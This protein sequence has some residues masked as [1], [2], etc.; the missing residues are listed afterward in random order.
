[1]WIV[2]L[3]LR[4]TYT[5]VVAA[6]LIAVLGAV[7][8]YR[9]ST[10]MFPNIDVPIVSVV[11]QFTGM[12]A[13]EIETRIIFINERVLTASVNNIEH[14]ESQSLDGVGVIR[15]Y[16]HP[17][18]NV[19][20]AETQVTATCQ[21]LLK[22]M[23]PGITP[24]YIVRY[25][26]TSVP[27]V[28]IAVSSDTLTEQQIF[29][30]CQNF[31]IQQLGIVQG[32]RVP[33]PWGGKQRQIMVDLD[34]DR[35]YA[36]GLSPND[37]S[38]AI[39][40]QN[41]IIPAGTAKMGATEYNVKLNS[42]PD[43]IAAFNDVPIKTVNGVPIYVKNVAHVRDG[44]AV[45]TN[46]VRRDGR[47]AVLMTVL[48][49]EGASTLDVVQRVRAALPGIQA[50]LPPE[51]KMEPLFDQ[52]VFVKAAIE[53]VLKEGA[54]AAGL[55]ALMILLFLGSWRSTL[56][57]ATSIPLSILASIIVLWALGQSL[58]SMTLGGMAL[59][60]GILVDDATVELENVHRNLGFNKPI[61]RAILDGAAQ[62]AVPA[63]VSTLAICIVF[64]PVVFLTGPAA[65]LFTPLALAVVFAM[66]TSYLLSRTLVPTMVLYLLPPEISLYAAESGVRSQETGVRSQETG[67]RSQRS[68][69][70]PLTPDSCLLT[71]DP[72][73]IWR[74]HHAFNRLFE[75][76]RSAYQRLL[77]W[78]LDHRLVTVAVMLGF[79][80]GSL[81]LF[82]RVGRDFFP[83]VDAGQFRLHVRAPAGTRVEATEGIFG[84]VEDA[85]R[86]V[87]PDGE[88]AMILDNMGLTQSFTI[89]AYVDNG[90]VSNADGEI[91]VS[92]K[93]N[94]RPTADYVARLR[95]ELPRR[96]PQCTFFFEP[97]DITSQILNFN[98]PAP[99]DVQVVGVNRD[100]NLAVAQ[101][102]RQEIAK[103]PGVAD[104]HLHQMTDRPNLGL[105]VDRIM[106]SELGLTQQDVSGSV[107]V[108]LSST[109]QVSP[110]FWVNPT[111][112]VNY[113]VAVQ[114]PE[115]RIHSLDTLLNTPVI[116][117]KTPAG[118]RRQTINGESQLTPP[119][120]LSNLVDLRRTVSPA[121]VNHY[122]V[123]PVYDVFANVQGRD[124]A[125]VAA[126][127]Q[128][129]IDAVR[130]EL[131][132]GSTIVMRGQV[133]TMNSSFTG[134]A[135]GLGFAVLLVYFLMV[136]NFQSWLDPFII[137]T[138]L[139]GALAGI[140]WMLYVS[141]TTVSVP[142][143]MGAIMCIGVAT[144]NSILMV[145]FAND[146]QHE[147]HDARA[148]ALA[149]GATRLRPV[150]MTALAMMIG[151]LP[152]SL[153][154]G[155]GGEQNA[156]LGRAVIGGLLVATFFTLFFVPVTYS[157]LRRRPP[158]PVASDDD[159]GAAGSPADTP[160]PAAPTAQ[161]SHDPDVSF[162]KGQP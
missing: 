138:A 11:W 111:N 16:F 4:R 161:A 54:I 70:R 106:A 133:E 141:Q 52:S 152:M 21:T 55:T 1:M 158:V 61:R 14:I 74:V 65:Y 80:F 45:Q 32:A 92:L 134:L 82:P 136:V 98:L 119:Q 20:E 81:L 26:A 108:S 114:T 88:R 39:S 8:I 110:N 30:Y 38:T 130:P 157:V 83:A 15:I 46:V 64:V 122:N 121:N 123:Q 120:L 127:V 22:I 149:A 155:E 84:Q 23:P 73:P 93:P 33:Q 10:D 95:Q 129:A 25:S 19:A 77:G 90:T 12:P 67:D 44:Y 17:G 105:N 72:G 100:G 7:S 131:P 28:Q 85:I 50:Q 87:V 143:L 132:R 78:A 101:K 137:L 144:S 9:T 51:L 112:R 91:L 150:L 160:H 63:L 57:V 145:T 43:L 156:P 76:L 118:G 147:G 96:F 79:A 116:S 18:A 48:K 107:L 53:G 75:R 104:V 37:V 69:N 102:L 139:P 2:R 126:D 71:P 135:T 59:A 146:Q 56:I 89:M 40:N 47:R 109:T 60:V 66:L 36:L 29:D 6:L 34:L 86:E 125:A 159:D 41:L 117:G 62:I 27:I 49:G 162:R 148:A 153:G 68:S 97:A 58:N 113:R 140:L 5:F 35:L 142:A 13:D 24:P 124:L 115:Y 99:I 103:V 154:L 151:M 128:K 31:I 3:A 42:S 94:H